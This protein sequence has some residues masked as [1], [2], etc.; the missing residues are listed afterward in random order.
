MTVTR[1][2]SIH[3]DVVALIAALSPEDV[4]YSLVHKVRALLVSCFAFLALFVRDMPEN[5]EVLFGSVDVLCNWLGYGVGVE[6]TISEVLLLLPAFCCRT[7]L[8]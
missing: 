5:Q 8:W 4:P 3:R 2:L 7:E 6:L 1:N